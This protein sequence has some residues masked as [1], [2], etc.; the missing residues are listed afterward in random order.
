MAKNKY[1]FRALEDTYILNHFIPK[2]T[3]V[4]ANFWAVHN[5]PKLWDKP[6]QFNPTR[7]LTDDG[8]ELIKHDNFIPFAIGKF[9]FD[10]LSC[11]FFREKSTKEQKVLVQNIFTYFKFN[12]LIGKRACVGET[13]ARVEVFLY[14]V[15]LLQRYT[16]SAP[17]GQSI[18][19]E[20]KFGLSLQPKVHSLLVFNKRN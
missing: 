10:S 7:F 6:D 1:I 19:F 17:N 12:L 5:D 18:S 3:L 11:I 2:D 15:S 16:I 13:L 4:L 20:E 14:F 8:K 9:R